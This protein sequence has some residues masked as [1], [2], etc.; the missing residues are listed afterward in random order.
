M[1]LTTQ[2]PYLLKEHTALC[3]MLKFRVNWTNIEQDTAIQKL[4][5]SLMETKFAK[6]STEEQTYFVRKGTEACEIVCSAIASDDGRRCS[7]RF[8]TLKALMLRLS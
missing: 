4:V 7:K 6:V 8:A 1:G 5:T 2:N 3:K